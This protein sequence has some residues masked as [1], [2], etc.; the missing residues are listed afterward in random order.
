MDQTLN[1]KPLIAEPRLVRRGMVYQWL[2]IGHGVLETLVALG[3]GVAAGSVVLFG[4]GLDSLI[5][6]LSAA[7]VVWRLFLQS[8]HTRRN[9]ADRIGLRVVGICFVGLGLYVGYDA[10]LALIHREIPH[11]SL[12][13]M[14]LAAFSVVFMPLLARAKRNLAQELES[15]AMGADSVQSHLCAC[16]S[17]ILLVGLV[18]NWAFHWWWADPAAALLMVPI[19]LRE[20]LLALQGKSCTCN[21][22]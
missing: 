2:T 19:I 16:L 10:I 17:G 20:G 5:E 15:S 14:A 12:P 7:I 18:L 8:D 1:H 6:V 13:G 3:A 4:F 9:I 21:N 11:E 22:H